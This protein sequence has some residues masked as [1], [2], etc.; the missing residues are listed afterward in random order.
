ME[1]ELH[2]MQR[3]LERMEREMAKALDEVHRLYRRELV[4]YRPPQTPARRG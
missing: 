3:R 2:R 1:D 4:L